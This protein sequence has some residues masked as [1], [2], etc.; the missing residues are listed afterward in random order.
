MKKIHILLFL[1]LGLP[2]LHLTAQ[3]QDTEWMSTFYE[4]M[5]LALEGHTL[6]LNKSEFLESNEKLI[7]KAFQ[8]ATDPN[9]TGRIVAMILI[10]L[11]ME[12]RS[13]MSMQEATLRARQG[14]V[15][16]TRNRS[17]ELLLNRLVSIRRKENHQ[18]TGAHTNGIKRGKK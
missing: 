17:P 4:S 16:T 6:I 13:G 8:N 14:L 9:E 15:I 10:Q 2:T 18:G 3:N 7:L 1:I 12:M 11:E 5:D